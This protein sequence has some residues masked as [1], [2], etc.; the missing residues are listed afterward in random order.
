MD[1]TSQIPAGRCHCGCGQLAPIA[2]HSHAAKG[3]VKG[4]PLRFVRGHMGGINAARAY[5]AKLSVA[6]DGAPTKLC[7]WRNHQQPLTEFDAS[8]HRPDRLN[9]H[10]KPCKNEQSKAR[11]K[12]D[13]SPAK[14]RARLTRKKARVAVRARIARIKAGGCRICPERNPCCIE[15]H[16][17]AGKDRC[18]AHC[19]SI[20]ALEREIARCVVLCSNCHRKAH[21]GRLLVPIDLLCNPTEGREAA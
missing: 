11:Y 9:S 2:K 7:T 12:L 14:R 1:L 5:Q 10:C 6:A 19:Q 21:A 8:P 13:P 15:F 18:V 4:Q 20:P 16:H 17:I 3:W